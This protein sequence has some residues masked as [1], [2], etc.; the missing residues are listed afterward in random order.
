MLERNEKQLCPIRAPQGAK[1]HA[2][3]ARVK[4]LALEEH[5]GRVYKW[6]RSRQPQRGPF[7][8]RQPRPLL[9]DVP[10]AL[11]LKDPDHR[12][13]AVEFLGQHVEDHADD[14]PPL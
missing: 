12:T 8:P 14:L 7:G 4:P 11:V 5:Q 2:T 10:N 3:A 6:V 13:L 9:G 1:G